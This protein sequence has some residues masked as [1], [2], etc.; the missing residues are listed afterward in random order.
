MSKKK[1]G[2]V[3]GAS[4]WEDPINIPLRGTSVGQWAT[5]GKEPRLH[6]GCNRKGAVY[7]TF[8]VIEQKQMK[9]MS[10]EKVEPQYRPGTA[11]GYASAPPTKQ[12]Q[13]KGVV[14][15][16]PKSPENMMREKGWDRLR[17]Q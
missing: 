3:S 11:R 1:T 6:V 5:A 7:G 10:Q 2:A 8:H 4:Y 17:K 14:L 9:M 15:S 13:C 16:I 12:N